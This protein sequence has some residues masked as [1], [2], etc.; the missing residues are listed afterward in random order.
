MRVDYKG[1]ECNSISVINSLI[2]TTSFISYTFGVLLFRPILETKFFPSQIKLELIL[3]H[4]TKTLQFELE[5]FATIFNKCDTK[6]KPLD[7]TFFISYE[8]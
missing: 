6:L 1:L 5:N 7:Y 4:L 2:S 8:I 3:F